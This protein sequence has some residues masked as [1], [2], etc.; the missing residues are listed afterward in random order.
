MDAGVGIRAGGAARPQLASSFPR[1]TTT[2][3][4]TEE[5][6]DVI[7]GRSPPIFTIIG[8]ELVEAVATAA[9]L[10][11]TAIAV[12]VVGVAAGLF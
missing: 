2:T 6:G 11:V 7:G 3:G 12:V 8:A 4:Q 10:V 1:A 9:V 5:E